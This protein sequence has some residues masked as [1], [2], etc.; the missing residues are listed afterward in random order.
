MLE[1]PESNVIAIQLN[2]RIVGKTIKKVV[3]DYSPHKFAFYWGDPQLYQGLIKGKKIGKSE[4]FGGQIE[5]TCENYKILLG[6]GV[7]IRLFE[8]E[9]KLPAKHQL[10]IEFTDGLSI[11]CSVQMYG[12]MWIFEEGTNDSKYYLIAKEK[13]SPLSKDF[14]E[15][16]FQSLFS[17]VKN[18]MSIKA[19][20]ATE[21]R[22]P[23]L[24]N[25]VLQDIL[26]NGGLNPRTKINRLSPDKIHI[27]YE[28]IVTTLEKMVLQG[29]RDTEKD[30]FG[31][32]GG[33]KTILSKN[34]V[35]APCAKCG[36]NIKKESYLGGS[37]YY[38]PNCQPLL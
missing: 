6:D 17:Q 15:E 5:I 9:E 2:K 4:S 36:G 20:L 29:G 38:C 31:R 35:K 23:G 1:F 11:V 37:V 3:A 22:I 19:F 14:T 16:Y 7:N 28:S 27:V 33:Y 32:Q 30:L 12:G 34:T 10:H 24:G 25:G 13:P 18:T 8:K 26:F 21:Q